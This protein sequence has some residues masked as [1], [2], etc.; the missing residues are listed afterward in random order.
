MQN[1]KQKT[2]NFLR[3]TQKY[4]GTDNVYLAKGGFWLSLGNIFSS[5]AAFLSSVAFANLID[6]FT[7]GNYRYVL[8]LLGIL[9][10]FSLPALNRTLIQAIAR[11]SEGTLKP[12]FKEKIKYGILGSFAATILGVYYLLEGNYL[13]T[14]PLFLCAIFL[15]LM[16]ASSIYGS[17]LG[18][19]KLFSYQVKYSTLSQFISVGSVVLALFLTKNLIW[20]VFVYLFSHTLVNLFFYFFVNQK[21]KPNEKEDPKTISYG[22]HLSMIGALG[23][24]ASQLDKI[25]VFHFLGGANLAIYAF[26]LAPVKQ[27]IGAFKSLPTLAVPKLSQRPIKEI[28]KTLIKRMLQLFFFGIIIALIYFFLA[29]YFFKIFYPKYLESIPYSQLLSILIILQLPI[30]F[31]GSVGQA[32]ITF[33]PKKWLYWGI[34][35]QI[36]LIISLFF[37]VQLY[38]I[39]GV[40]YSQII[41]LAVLIVF[42]LLRWKFVVVKHFKKL[43]NNEGKK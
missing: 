20:I 17:L 25:L 36:V 38:Q 2:Y 6:P 33:F 21:F 41:F 26:A 15:P 31:M 22:K 34:I 7:Y 42:G 39:Y 32:K 1:L 24:F 28:D 3:R 29:P 43:E 9:A 35:P 4:T 19:R 13:L 14:V 8:S 11:G 18:G 5:V 40:I 37:L 23:K 30:L 12:A 27:I 16:Q 10:I